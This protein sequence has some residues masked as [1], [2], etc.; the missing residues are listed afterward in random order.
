[1]LLTTVGDD[2][3]NVFETFTYSEGESAERF[4]FRRRHSQVQRNCRP[5]RNVVYERFCSGKML[6]VQARASTSTSLASV[7]W[8]NRATSWRKTT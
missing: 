6:R 4:V 3:V 1:M 8:R 5:V 7:I 2:T